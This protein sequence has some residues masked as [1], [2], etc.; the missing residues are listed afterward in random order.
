M[1]A[2]GIIIAFFLKKI[3][4]L[5]RMSNRNRQKSKKTPVHFSDDEGTEDPMEVKEADGLIK[6]YFDPSA[7]KR[8]RTK[9]N[10]AAGMDHEIDKKEDDVEMMMSLGWVKDKSEV[11]AIISEQKQSFEA[12]GDTN[13]HKDTRTRGSGSSNSD[14]AGKQ[15][16]KNR[17]EKRGTKQSNVTY[18]YSKVG[19][20]G[21]GGPSTNDNPFF[22]G[23]AVSG[24]SQIQS[25]VG[26]ERKKGNPGRKG[27][28][29]NNTHTGHSGNKSYVYRGGK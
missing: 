12:S 15:Q 6:D 3:F 28:K 29:R 14:G 18:D 8:Q 1:R 11:D 5:Q 10:D 20:I 17:R 25:G 26:K 27:G 7:S 2:N 24:G 19:S 22:A 16:G 13:D 23:A 21:V 4:R 9:S